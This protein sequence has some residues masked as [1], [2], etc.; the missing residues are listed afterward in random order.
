MQDTKRR[1]LVKTIVWR[2]YIVLAIVCLLLAMG[3]PWEKAFAGSVVYN[4]VMTVAF[5]VYDR[6]WSHIAWGKN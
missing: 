6:I 3:E 2:A 4:V 1:S 5:Y